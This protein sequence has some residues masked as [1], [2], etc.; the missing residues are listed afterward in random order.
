MSPGHPSI[1][2]Q[3]LRFHFEVA[4]NVLTRAGAKK[5]TE[6]GSSMIN[7]NSLSSERSA[8]RRLVVGL[9][10]K[11]YQSNGTIFELYDGGQPQQP[12]PIRWQRLESIEGI[13][14][15]PPEL[16]RRLE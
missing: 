5:L 13:A 8:R 7:H 2:D 12:T 11:I 1:E 10:V 3:V 14:S 6:G 15:E 9:P 16:H 4:W